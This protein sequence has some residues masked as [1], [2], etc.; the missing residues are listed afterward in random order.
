MEAEFWLRCWQ[1][2]QLGWQLD[3]PHPLLSAAP[4]DWLDSRPVFVPLCGKSPDLHFLAMTAPVVGSEL[5]EL[6]CSAFFS[7]RGLAV[8]HQTDGGFGCFHHD[9][10]RLW[11]GDFF[12]LQPSQ[13]SDCQRIYDRAALIALPEQMR[14]QYVAKLRFLLPQADL[15][16]LSLEYPAGEKQGP[17]FNVPEA[18]I[19]ALFDFATVQPLQQ[20]DLTGQG[21]GRRR[22]DTSQLIETCWRIRWA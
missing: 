22:F 3:T 13:L 9:N 11:Q 5:S 12:A 15:L 2:D 8:Q 17:P 7:E 10:I 19:R 6:A 21:F 16:L 18:E 14:R 20:R 1:Q 4:A